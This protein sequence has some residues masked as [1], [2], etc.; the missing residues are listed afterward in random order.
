MSPS[1]E[2]LRQQR[3]D[4]LHLLL[5]N[6]TDYAIIMLDTAGNVTTWDEGAERL[7]GYTADEIIGRPVSV[8]FIA[9]DRAAGRPDR[10]LE[11]A[12]REGRADDENWLVR[13]DGTLLWVDGSP[14]ALRDEDGS[15]HGY[16]KI[17]HD[18]TER[19]QWEETL[20]TSERRFR[21]LIEHSSDAI[22]LNDAAG[23]IT[24]VSPSW[25]KLSHHPHGGDSSAKLL[26]RVSPQAAPR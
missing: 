6:V 19:K 23:V 20:T 3:E 10:E 9:E 7:L 26:V 1:Q 14:T 2:I 25:V 21:A 16:A 8:F 22:V 4:L 11:T 15:L 18:I 12:R 17:V 5:P 24:Y 13:N